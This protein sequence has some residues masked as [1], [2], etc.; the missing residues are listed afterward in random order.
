M[1]LLHE[2]QAVRP[3]ALLAN[4]ELWPHLQWGDGRYIQTAYVEGDVTMANDVY[5]FVAGHTAVRIEVDCELA[6]L[7]AVEEAV[8]TIV[9]RLRLTDETAL[10]E[11]P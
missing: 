11:R 4:C 9:A 7:L 5:L 10:E 2:L 6:Q 1:G 3:D 8:A